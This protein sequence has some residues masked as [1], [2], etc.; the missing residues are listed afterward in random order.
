MALSD[1][2]ILE[3]QACRRSGALDAALLSAC[4]ARAWPTQD[5]AERTLA[6]TREALAAAAAGSSR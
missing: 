3:L 2:T 1:A 6:S 4:R 5:D